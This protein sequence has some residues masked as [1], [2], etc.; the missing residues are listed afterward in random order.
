M[1]AISNVECS[2]VD[3]DQ[4]FIRRL[5][6][7]LIECGVGKR[8]LHLAVLDM[9]F[10]QKGHYPHL[11]IQDEKKTDGEK[12]DQLIADILSYSFGS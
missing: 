9:F 3:N 1:L 5:I 8:N 7:Y 11:A 12:I 2:E 4:G 10:D 6:V